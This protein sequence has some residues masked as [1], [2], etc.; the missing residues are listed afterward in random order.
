VHAYSNQSW[1]KC[2][3]AHD[4]VRESHPYVVAVADEAM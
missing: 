1:V 2:S 4:V 3:A